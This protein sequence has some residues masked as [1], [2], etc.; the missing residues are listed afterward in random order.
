MIK[1]S[2]WFGKMDSDKHEKCGKLKS[3]KQKL[4]KI[5]IKNC[6]KHFSQ[7]SARIKPYGVWLYVQLFLIYL[8]IQFTINS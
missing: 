7:I 8:F 4:A 3:Q 6:S 2:D 5:R 1:L